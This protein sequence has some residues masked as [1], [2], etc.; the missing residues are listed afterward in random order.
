[1]RKNFGRETWGE[2]NLKDPDIYGSIVLKR[3]K[4]K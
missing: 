4:K 1:M 3:I 2:E